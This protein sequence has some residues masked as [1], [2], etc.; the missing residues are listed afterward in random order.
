[1]MRLALGR[2]MTPIGQL[3]IAVD[4]GGSL[5]AAYFADD[6]STIKRQLRLHYGEKGFELEPAVNPHGVCDALA[7]YF[8]GDL[9]AIE[10]L[11]VE[12]GGTAFQK[13]VWQALR[14]IEWGTTI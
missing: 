3:M 14:E 9:A 5:R 1:M 8:S 2:M 12:T 4:D 11:K 6:E 7:S 10:K 13:E